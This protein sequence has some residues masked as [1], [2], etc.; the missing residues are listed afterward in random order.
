MRFVL[1][2]SP[3]NHELV[4]TLNAGLQSV[5][6]PSGE[7]IQAYSTYLH[8]TIHWWQH[9]GSTAG[10]LYSLCYPA[11][12]HS[13]M[14]SLKRVAE[15]IGP[16]KSIKTW[17]ENA[18]IHG[19]SP[20]KEILEQAN[21]AVN[22]SIDVEY[23][24]FF[25]TQPKNADQLLEQQYFECVGHSYNIAYGQFLDLIASVS[26][27]GSELLPNKEKWDSE[28]RRLKSLQHEGFYHGSNIRRSRIGLHAI[29]EGQAR[30][31][32]LQFLDNAN[33][34]PISCSE[35][36]KNGYL[37]GIYVEA[38]AEFL[39]LT[40]SKWPKYIMDPIVGL[41]LLVCDLAIN[42][43]R[44]IPFTIERF[45][46]F[47]L[48]VDPGI[49]FTNLCFAIN[50]MPAVKSA[51]VNYSREEYVSVSTALTEVAGYDSEIASLEKISNWINEV[52][53][54]RDLMLEKE[55]FDYEIKNIVVRVIFSH[56]LS[57]S[58]DKLAHPEFYCWTGAWM[59][60]DRA[61]SLN[62]QLLLSHL[63]LFSDRADKDGIY[64]RKQPGKSAESVLNTF[65][66]FYGSV[67]LY[68]MTKQWV[69]R[70]G[71]FLYDYK[72]LTD[73]SRD[74]LTKWIKGQFSKVYGV[75]PDDFI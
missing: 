27:L 65:N 29:F 64:P 75:N 73:N 57:F 17:A 51:I 48:D 50:S 19:T 54:I 72:W 24:K 15:T 38:F 44:G 56:F 13:S 32:Q 67:L 31:I 4:D 26:G 69:L 37:D 62:L 71:H 70:D 20:N 9:M 59:T 35:W 41:F 11:Q 25:V 34:N 68:D 8:E 49:R 16:V 61:S 63:S 14:E 7:L 1:R 21:T 45:E 30:F 47:I 36:A 18:A 2:L 55:T 39:R 33:A 74:E 66:N 40:N 60:G 10:L 6:D 22:N 43:T 28:F 42:P 53:E 3:K 12:T 46:T 58:K 23:Y 52:K 5:D